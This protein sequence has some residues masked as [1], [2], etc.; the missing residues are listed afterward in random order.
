MRDLALDTVTGDLMLD[1]AGAL[2]TTESAATAV[3]LALASHFDA[4]WGDPDAGSRLHLLTR[5]NAVNGL[6]ADV[7]DEA[8]RALQP[9]VSRGRIAVMS[10]SATR[11]KQGR[12]DVETRIQDNSSGAPVDVVV[13]VFGGF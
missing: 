5:S 12:I 1:G 2:V 11:T 6:E 3:R 9:L 8:R 4:W 10:V 7:E 13:T